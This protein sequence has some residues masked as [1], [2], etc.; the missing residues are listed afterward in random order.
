MPDAILYRFPETDEPLESNLKQRTPAIE[1]EELSYLDGLELYHGEVAADIYRDEQVAYGT[2]DGIVTETDETRTNVHATVYAS[3]QTG[4]AGITT[5]KAE[6]VLERALLGQLGVSISEASVD[7]ESFVDTNVISHRADVWAVAYSNGDDE[8]DIDPTRAGAR[9]HSDARLSDL[10]LEDVSLLGIRMSWDGWS[11]KVLVCESGY[12]AVHEDSISTEAFA[13]WI[14]ER[15]GPH[16][17]DPIDT[18][19]QATLEGTA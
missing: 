13:R 1:V 17:Y 9:Y 18:T 10:E 15:I 11:L 16:L 8:L 19:E 4:W 6:R 2:P 7:I 12:V 5:R 3:P 14:H